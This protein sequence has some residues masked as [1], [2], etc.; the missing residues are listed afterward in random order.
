MVKFIVVALLAAETLATVLFAQA[1][2]VL[3]AFAWFFVSF[4]LG[5]V[6]VRRAGSRAWSALRR[7]AGATDVP[8]RND[9]PGSTVLLFLAGVLL[10]VP[11]V[12]TDLVGLL[13]LLPP[14]RALVAL[15]AARS[16]GKRLSGFRSVV[17]TVRLADGSTVIAGEVVDEPG[18]EQGRRPD[19]PAHPEDEPPQLPPR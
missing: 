13:L 18:T 16:A 19:G 7:S 8:A 4:V 6:V 2:G 10:C 9:V 5:I 3:W 12:L 15:W 1:V 11:G 14:V 17:T